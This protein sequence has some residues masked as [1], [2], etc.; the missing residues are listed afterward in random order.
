MKKVSIASL[1]VLLIVVAGCHKE[2]S[3]DNPDKKDNKA[4]LLGKWKLQRTEE[5]YWH[6][7]N[8]LVDTDVI[9]GEAGDSAIFFNDRVKTYEDEN[10][11]PDE[12]ILDF[13]WVNDSTIT[14][15]DEQFVIR[16]LTDSELYLHQDYIN[17]ADDTK[18]VYRVFMVR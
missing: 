10:G 12:D 8:M 6:P 5:E 7:V 4:K 9:P 18:D 14:I 3:E 16:K 2:K 15:D 1:I 11:Q 13:K 17:T